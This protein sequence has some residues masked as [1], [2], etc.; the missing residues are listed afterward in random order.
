METRRRP[1]RTAFCRAASTAPGLADVVCRVG[2]L[3]QPSVV[4]R[5]S[6]A[7]GRRFARGFVFVEDKSVSRR[8]ASLYPG[9]PVRLP[10]YNSRRAP[11]DRRLV[12]ARTPWF[13]FSDH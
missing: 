9:H 6:E 7:I 3:S 12:A 1:P 5:I 4:Q 2:L 10:V 11:R 8:S 13:V